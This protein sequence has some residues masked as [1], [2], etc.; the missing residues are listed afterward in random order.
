MHFTVSPSVATNVS[1]NVPPKSIVFA[2]NLPKVDHFRVKFDNFHPKN[3]LFL[4]LSFFTIFTQKRNYCSESGQNDHFQ[5]KITNLRP[6][7]V[8]FLL[9]N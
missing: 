2:L 4:N 5:A 6:N 9:K 8:H 3:P 7:L 1:P